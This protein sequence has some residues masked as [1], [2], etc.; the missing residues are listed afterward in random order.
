MTD[1]FFNYRNR[2]KIKNSNV[3]HKMQLSDVLQVG[4]T[5]I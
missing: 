1:L 5:E 4:E 2:T 3:Y